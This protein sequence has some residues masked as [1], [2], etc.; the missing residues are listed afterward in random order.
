MVDKRQ[1]KKK[2]IKIGKEGPRTG[3]RTSGKANSSAGLPN[4]LRADSGRGEKT[5]KKR[6][7]NWATGFSSL[8]LFWVGLPSHLEDVFSFACQMK[9]SCTTGL[10]ATSNFCCSETELRKLQTPLTGRSLGGGH[11]KPLLYSC[12]ENPMDRGAW[13]AIALRVTQSQTWLKL[14]L[15]CTCIEDEKC[16]CTSNRRT[17][18]GSNSQLN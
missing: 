4:L 18:Q 17:L 10:S 8:R 7:Q 5:Y 16:C 9:L 1:R 12:L 13:R 3:V 6:S 11:G 14:T 15:A 2:P